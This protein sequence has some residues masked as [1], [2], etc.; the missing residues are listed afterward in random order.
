MLDCADTGSIRLMAEG[1]EPASA[2]WLGYAILI[3]RLF[4]LSQNDFT[5]VKFICIMS[6]LNCTV[7]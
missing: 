4:K 3:S 2:G 1:H 6:N 7:L 5:V